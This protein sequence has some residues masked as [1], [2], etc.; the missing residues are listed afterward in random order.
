[1][2]D[3]IEPCYKQIAQS[4][5]DAISEAWTTAKVTAV[6]YSDSISFYAEY[7]READGV[8]RSFALDMP[9]TRAFRQ[10]R[11]LFK[12]AGQ[13]LWGKAHFVLEENG[14]FNMNWSYDNCDEHGDTLWD[15][16][17]WHRQQEEFSLR[18]TKD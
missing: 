5:T 7:A 1:M 12:D 4:I 10:V 18:C 3:G 17:E 9:G 15:E 2:I 16:E 8:I 13:P 6:F 11:R 14:R